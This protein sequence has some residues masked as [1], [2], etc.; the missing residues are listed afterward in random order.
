[1]LPLFIILTSTIITKFLE[2]SFAQ[3]IIPQHGDDEA[4][5]LVQA[6]YATS[7]QEA[8]NSLKNYKLRRL[9]DETSD[10]VERYISVVTVAFGFILHAKYCY[11]VLTLKLF[12]E[13]VWKNFLHYST[14]T[15]S[16]SHLIE[17]T[18]YQMKTASRKSIAATCNR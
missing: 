13:L 4:E 5:V 2:N 18:M 3:Y 10:F 11:A 1:V 12:W 14:T 17:K 16:R 8:Q 7:P 15:P 9:L 6:G